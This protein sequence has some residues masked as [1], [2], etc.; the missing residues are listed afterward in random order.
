[1]SEKLLIE[2][3]AKDKAS[4]AIRG[5]ASATKTELKGISDSGKSTGTALD[6]GLTAGATAVKGVGT[7]AGKT[8]ADMKGM[9]SAAKTSGSQVQGEFKGIASTAKTSGDQTE[10]AMKGVAGSTKGVG[11]S[12]KAA[13]DQTETS[14][15]SMAGA[16]KTYQQEL[17]AV[18]MV[19]VG[20]GV[21]T[22]ALASKAI[23]AYRV[24][25]EAEQRLAAAIEGSSQVIDQNRL[26]KLAADLQQLTTVGDETIITVQAILTTFNLTQHQIEDLTPRVLNIAAVLGGDLK[27]NAV[28]VGKAFGADMVSALVRYGIII[29]EATLKSGDFNSLLKAIDANT[30]PMAF[31]L[32]E[33][34]G[35]TKQFAN[36]MGDLNELIGKALLPAITTILP[37]LRE[38]VKLLTQIAETPGGQWLIKGGVAGGLGLGAV[39][40][41]GLAGPPVARGWGM[42][43]AGAG[44]VAGAVGLRA[45]AGAAAAEGAGAIG[46]GAAARG[47]AGGVIARGGA[48]LAAK[49]LL[50]AVPYVGTALLA[51]EVGAMVWNAVKGRR[52]AAEAEAAMPAPGFEERQAA[53]A[54]SVEEFIALASAGS[55]PQP[56]NMSAAQQNIWG[57]LG[58][59]EKTQISQRMIPRG[60][61]FAEGTPAL[62]AISTEAMISDK[63]TAAAPRSVA[64]LT[65]LGG[66][67]FSLEAAAEPSYVSALRGAGRGPRRAAGGQMATAGG[68][69]VTDSVG[70]DGGHHIEI[71]IPGA[72]IPQGVITDGANE[73]LED[74][75]YAYGGSL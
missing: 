59:E 41:L 71:F 43:R 34:A 73:Y 24:Q 31:K 6:Q 44:R 48:K 53:Q 51:A 50:R 60:P 63:L 67:A 58:T 38:F 23:A 42:A 54:Q 4:A 30:G 32:A 52:E 62:S 65:E 70:S 45:A 11:T 39:G 25:E 27:S 55:L 37:P 49:G 20:V 26:M 57:S 68:I 75:G 35:A 66:G 74:F 16:A 1:M 19:L 29:D 28:A 3:D 12:A 7:A 9:A 13:A 40:L 8:G 21:A 72:D 46:A 10:K 5:V 33:G 17:R 64:G 69:R 36:E 47:V 15:R 56:E 14:F 61:A 2:I 18:S 22:V